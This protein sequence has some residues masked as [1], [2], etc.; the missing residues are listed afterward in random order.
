MYEIPVF[1]VS[2]VKEAT[3][4]TPEE[5]FR[6]PR[7]LSKV[8]SKYF[9]GLDREH[10]I[11]VSLNSA[12]QIIGINTV[13]IGSLNQAIVHPRETF[14]AAI[15]CN[16]AAIILA[17]NHPSGSTKPS[18]EDRDITDRL[19]KAGELLGIKVLDHI[20]MG[21]GSDY[22]SFTT[23]RE[24]EAERK[25]DKDRLECR[26][27][28]LEYAQKR[29]QAG[30]ATGQDIINIAS[31]RLGAAIQLKTV[32]ML[33]EL[34]DIIKGL[35]PIAEKKRGRP[36]FLRRKAAEMIT[37]IKKLIEINSEKKAA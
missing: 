8:L 15:L 6:D 9:H 30:H 37:S 12:N 33:P 31:Y 27:K 25:R 28:E 19:T 23:E 21:E 3:L 1:K 20:I 22:F 35:L 13:S 14:K 32:E 16:A 24:A 5:S 34:E 7:S 18:Q 10:F 29:L 11:A 36:I 17:H 4:K 2:L 26:K